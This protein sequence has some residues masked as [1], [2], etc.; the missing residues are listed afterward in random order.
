MSVF[1]W[2]FRGTTSAYNYI[3]STLNGTIF[4]RLVSEAVGGFKTFYVYISTFYLKNNYF[5]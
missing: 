3:Y 4:T 2:E 1:K 5:I